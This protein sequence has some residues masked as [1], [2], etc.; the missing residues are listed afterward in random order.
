[1]NQ[2]E[3]LVVQVVYRQGVVKKFIAHG[4]ILMKDF[5]QQVEVFGR[6]R[7][8]RHLHIV[9]DVAAETAAGALLLNGGRP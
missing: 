9:R 8:Y 2:R 1:M 7:L 3:L 4:D 5:I 6:P